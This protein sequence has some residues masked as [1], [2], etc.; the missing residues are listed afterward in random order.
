MLEKYHSCSALWFDYV[1]LFYLDTEQGL[2]VKAVKVHEN[3]NKNN[4][5]N[6]IALLQVEGSIKFGKH[7]EPLCIPSQ[8][9]EFDINAKC[10]AAGWGHTSFKGHSSREMLELEVSCLHQSRVFWSTH[11]LQRHRKSNKFWILSYFVYG[12]LSTKWQTQGVVVIILHIKD[13]SYL[14]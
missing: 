7:V 1:V 4:Y 10:F 5:H 12:D 3:Y 9:Y 8:G 13:R 14:T 6:D 2:L 11:F